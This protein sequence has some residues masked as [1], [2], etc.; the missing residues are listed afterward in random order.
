[1]GSSWAGIEEF[2]T[3]ARVRSFTQ[4]AK[5]LGVSASQ[6]SR[7]VARLEERLGQ[8]LL[9]RS[10][11]RVSLTEA[12]ER[13]LARAGHL[14]EERDDALVAMQDELPQLRGHLRLTCSERF[15]VPMMNRFLLRHPHVTIEVMLTN[16]LVD[17]GDHGV[18]LAVTFGPQRDSGLIGARLGSRSRHLCATPSYLEAR[19]VPVSPD[20]FAQHDCVCGMDDVWT[21][22]RDGRVVEHRPQGR[23]SCNSGYAVIDA[24]LAGL[25]LCQLPD[26]YVQ[27]HLRSGALVELLA[28]QRPP[29]EDVWAVYP[30]R[31]HLPAKVRM[32]IEHLQ[33]EFRDRAPVR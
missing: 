18:D 8:R 24:A 32:T 31:R 33:Q 26:F 27:P 11:R 3:V 28:E 5:R 20:E 4:A 19:G 15:V 17:F 23:L 21:F 7:E 14:I 25:G 10:T 9:Y 16:G 6:V 22:T 30:H 2:Y 13:F 1:M 12:G 29:A